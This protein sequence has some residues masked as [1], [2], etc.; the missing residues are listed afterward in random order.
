MLSRLSI[1]WKHAKFFSK[2]GDIMGCDSAG[3]VVQVGK[4]IPQ[5]VLGQRRGIMTR[6]GKSPDH[7]AFAEYA[8]HPFLTLSSV[9]LMTT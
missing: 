2:P 8:L 3:V 6:G 5:A 7:G 1:D 4:G 9:Q